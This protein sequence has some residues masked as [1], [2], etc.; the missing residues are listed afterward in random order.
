MADYYAGSGGG[1]RL[2]TLSPAF[3]QGAAG[4][5][6]HID[7]KP[8][9]VAKIYLAAADRRAYA[10]KIETMLA[11][12]PS[13][14]EIV[15]KGQRCV[16]IAWPT[17][18]IED[19]AGAFAGFIMPEVDFKKSR[20]LEDVLQKGT[21]KLDSIA[22]FYGYRVLL[23]ANLAALMA[24]LHA[25]GHY[26]VDMKPEN[27]RFYPD[28][29]Y[30]A[31]LDT[32][33]FSIKG[34]RTRIPSDQVSDNYIAPEARGKS[35]RDL[36]KSQD[37]FALAVIIFRLLN[38]GIH[39]YQGVNRKGSALPTE[40]QARIF[41]GLYSYA[42][43]GHPQV[44][45]KPASLH[46][47]FEDDT[48]RMFDRAFEAGAVRPTADEW[49]DHLKDLVTNRLVKCQKN[50][51]E[52]GHFS[53]GCGLCEEEQRL[54][55]VATAQM[56][57]RSVS[58]STPSAT[59]QMS[60]SAISGLQGR[61]SLSR[62]TPPPPTPHPSPVAG[63]PGGV[64]AWIIGAAA[65][66]ALLLVLAGAQNSSR[67]ST[68]PGAHALSTFNNPATFVVR[69]GGR[70]VYVNIRSGPGREFSSLEQLKP[71]TS[72]LAVGRSFSSAGDPWLAI[73]RRDG[74][75]GYVKESLLILA[76][77]FGTAP[78]SDADAASD[79]PAAPEVDVR[80][81]PTS[82]DC[83]RMSVWSEQQV[84][85]NQSLASAD[86][87]LA[88]LYRD[89][90]RQ[91]KGSAASRLRA[92]QAAWRK[93]RG[94]CEITSEPIGCLTAIYAQR[95]V[96]LRAWMPTNPTPLQ[97]ASIVNQHDTP[98]SPY[99]QTARAPVIRNPDWR[100]QPSGEEIGR[101]YPDR[102]MRERVD[103]HS[104]IRCIV[105]SSGS[106]RDCY[107][108]DETPAG[109]GFGEAAVRM[110]RLFRMTPR[111]VNGAAV[112]GGEVTIPLGWRVPR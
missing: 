20:M 32:D 57:K 107:V 104:T 44:M 99:V 13:L 16:Q 93:Q 102:A 72:L 80:T 71:G 66:G 82:F 78:A 10:T 76:G 47:T 91:A 55:V 28:L 9:M 56:Q 86:V 64:W 98:S 24:E 49:R 34:T 110:S 65:I 46:E 15:E 63:P 2:L 77:A 38:N 52:H 58:P 85:T 3:A 96:Q 33:G 50:P 12:P 84:C 94:A 108:V 21:R 48:R 19:A 75:L 8:G 100:R 61:A 68:A 60:A 31:I 1:R 30:M 18:M 95:A 7:G 69:P 6:H 101:F 36:G 112:D 83:S 89:R 42:Q 92:D 73:R 54:V 59:P 17:E 5:I 14:P 37:L 103:G 22:E 41:A 90:I 23:A 39:P 45:A 43:R 74:S 81:Y 105:A 67:G 106:L 97:D 40:L 11:R 87:D 88:T 79:A 70:A 25:R 109:F 51:A 27:M 62:S 53:R 111:M 4:A 35:P 29:W 26:M